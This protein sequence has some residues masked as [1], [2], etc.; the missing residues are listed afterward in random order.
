MRPK[1][2]AILGASG[3]IGR[4]TLAVLSELGPER[5][6][7]EVVLLA[8][9][10]SIEPLV[11]AAD[12][13]HCKTLAFTGI[14]D[15]AA[16]PAMGHDQRAFC[17]PRAILD[18]L[19][20][21]DP[22][23]VLNGITGAAGLGASLYAIEAGKSLL[24]ANKE[25]LVVAGPL[26]MG[27]ARR[28]GAQ[29]LPVDSE[30]AA[31]HQCLRGERRQDLKKI[32]LTASGG[33]FRTL[34]FDALQVVSVEAALAHPT[35]KMG[36]RISIGSATLMNKSFEVLEAHHLFDL[37][38]DEIDV[39]VHPQSIVHSMVGFCDGSILAQLGVP[40]M[41][42]PIAYCLGYPERM[43]LDFEGFD[44][45][46]FAELRFEAPDL[47]RFPALA[48]G[49]RCIE[50]GG[51]SGAILNAADEVATAA[52]LDGRIAFPR[53]AAIVEECLDAL[54]SEALESLDHVLDTDRRARE[55]AR[56]CVLET[57][58]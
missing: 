20:A 41:R 53:I 12:D 10:R 15:R 2:L 25:S 19:E 13:H 42:L 23:L 14:E 32:W 7:F 17:G 5:E 28:T 1:R 45:A 4:S 3:S 11:R 48:L 33:P 31:I 36:P 49:W 29:V 24:L 34:P 37:A 38:A 40:D 51:S 8:A 55:V 27:L 26:L 39:L 52:F 22:D 54:D 47:R 57:A 16:L 6:A 44:P 46:R 21:C 9:H 30:H 58:Q 56:T 18:A 43:N 35:W 50:A